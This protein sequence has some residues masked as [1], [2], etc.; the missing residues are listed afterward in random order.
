MSPEATIK[1]VAQFSK[2]LTHI[3]E[4]VSKAR[5]EWD[6]EASTRPGIQQTSSISDTHALLTAVGMG[7]GLYFV[8][9]RHWLNLRMKL[10]FTHEVLRNGSNASKVDRISAMAEMK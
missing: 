8:G 2:V 1:Q 7:K 3:F 6:V 9:L 5:E 10:E 4:M